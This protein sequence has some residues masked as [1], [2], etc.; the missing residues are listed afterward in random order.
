MPVGC[1]ENHPGMCLYQ[2]GCRPHAPLVPRE[3]ML[4]LIVGY[5]FGTLAWASIHSRKA[6]VL[7]EDGQYVPEAGSQGDLSFP[8]PPPAP[9]STRGGQE[10]ETP[11][12][13]ACLGHVVLPASHGRTVPAC[14][15]PR[16]QVT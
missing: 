2:M 11:K 5:F 1:L 7:L 8:V 6:C 9:G 13:S 4:W 10:A 12:A 16:P 14:F 15:T 3:I